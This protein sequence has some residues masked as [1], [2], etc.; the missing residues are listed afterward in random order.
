MKAK[1]S[2]GK[3]ILIISQIS[4]TLTLK[5]QGLTESIIKAVK[6]TLDVILRV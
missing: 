2:L 6:M 1:Y 5:K 3:F 4:W